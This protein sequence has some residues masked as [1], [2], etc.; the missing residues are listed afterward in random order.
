MALTVKWLGQS[1]LLLAGDGRNVLIDPWLSPHPERATPPP[2]LEWPV[3]IDLLLIT[4]GHGDHLDLDGLE[5]L[6]RHTQIAEIA[7]PFPHLASLEAAL[8]AIPCV[9]VRP[10]FTLDRLGGI[11]VLPA[12]HGVTT[13][14]GYGP[15]IG[16]DGTS[17]HV[18]YFFTLGGIRAYASGDTLAN[19]TL[20][21]M[22]RR[23]QPQLMFLPVNGRDSSREARG[24]LGNMSAAEA[25]DFAVAAGASILVPLHHDGV[26]GNTA[27]IGELARA[28]QGRPLHL[29]LPARSIP[30]V[31]DGT[32]P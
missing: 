14:D 25:L 15:M 11:A 22:V 26:A 4:H 6:A 2:R 20:L 10:H 9:G 30:F 31:L 24:I 13:A 3:R 19:D 27:D 21:D 7:A 12:W 29:I 17:P 23:W 5:G 8:P 1:G 18:G 16:A 32:R 28:A